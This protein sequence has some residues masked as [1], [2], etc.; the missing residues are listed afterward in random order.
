MRVKMSPEDM[1]W[2]DRMGILTD[3]FNIEWTL[4]QHVRDVSKEEMEEL[5]KKYAAA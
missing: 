1:F 3:P 5:A 2:G 4:A